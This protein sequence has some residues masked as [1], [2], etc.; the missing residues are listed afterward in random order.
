MGHG[1]GRPDQRPDRDRH[2]S[3]ALP[4]V[5]HRPDHQPDDRLGA[6]H[7]GPR[8][9]VRR[10]VL[11]F[12]GVL[13]S[14]RR[15]HVRGGRLDPRRLRALPAVP[16]PGPAR[17]RPALR[18]RPLRRRRTAEAFADRLR[19]DVDLASVQGDCWASSPA[20]CSRRPSPSGCATGGTR[21]VTGPPSWGPPDRL[22]GDRVAGGRG[23]AR[24]V[25]LSLVVAPERSNADLARVD[26]LLEVGLPRHRRGAGRDAAAAEQSS[27]GSSGRPP[28]LSPW[29]IAATIRDH[30]PGEQ[31]VAPGR[32]H[33][34]AWL[35]GLTFLPT[36]IDGPR[37]HPPAFPDRPPAE[38]VDGGGS[39]CSP[40][41]VVLSSCPRLH[42]GAVGDHPTLLNPIGI[43]ASGSM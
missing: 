41:R 21:D 28:S 15:Q 18:S 1:H 37:L 36:L 8:R 29:S 33:W 32:A 12:T 39:R 38:P 31:P 20:A 13:G 26:L 42:A 11:G 30:E 34:V 17:G 10:A 7:R 16:A 6:G 24:Y 5:R 25:A 2:R 9:V 40:G 22:A 23:R 19:N 27:A 14:L 35:S 43:A 3:P 4:A